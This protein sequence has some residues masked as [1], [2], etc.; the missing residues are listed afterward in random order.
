MNSYFYVNVNEKW[1]NFQGRF[2]SQM[3]NDIQNYI[4]WQKNVK[5]TQNSVK[6][7][8]LWCR[9]KVEMEKTVQIY[10]KMFG[11]MQKG[12]NLHSGIILK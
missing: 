5:N 1:Y 9:L 4:N 3:Q 11:K 8:I 10:S 2:T 12:E 6:I 7:H